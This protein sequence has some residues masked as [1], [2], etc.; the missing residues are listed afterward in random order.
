[1]KKKVLKEAY[2]WGVKKINNGGGLP[3]F[4]VYIDP[5]LSENSY[6]YKDQIKKYGAK[7]SGI[8]KYWYFEVSSDPQQRAQE[9]ETKVKP[10]V[11][12]LKSV[13][14]KP[15]N[16]NA[17]GQMDKIIS[18]IDELIGAART[19]GAEKVVD[20]V[21]TSFDPKELERRLEF[22]KEELIASFQNGTWKEKMAPIIKFRQAQGPS[23][24]FDNAILIQIQDPQSTMV[25][26]KSNW[27]AANK[28]VKAG[29][30]ALW[31]RVPLGKKNVTDKKQGTIDWL[32]KYGKTQQGNLTQEQIDQIVA[33]LTVGEKEKLKKYLNSVDAFGFKL[34]PGVYDVRFTEQ[35]EGKEDLIGSQEGIE[36]IAWYDGV[37]DETERSAHLYDAVVKAIEKS[38]VK[39][40]YTTDAE[41]DGARGVSVGG[42]IKVL[43]G[44]P[45][46]PGAVSTL[47]HEF[48]HELLHQNYLKR[49]DD[50]SK[51]FVGKQEGRA[52]VEQQAEISAWI[53]MRNFGYDMK[54]AVNYA[55]IWG[56]DDK[57]CVKVFNTVAAVAK[58][59]IQ[60]V[61]KEMSNVNESVLSEINLTGFDVARMLGSDALAAYKRGLQ[62]ME[63]YNNITETF[64]RV[65]KK[66]SR[67]FGY[68]EDEE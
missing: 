23:F 30:P 42:E 68:Y 3:M 8:G 28:N 1:M 40:S 50:L 22:F 14:K 58:Y 67:P 53:V 4:I 54:T 21:D 56:A 62:Q 55:G 7:W 20:E 15:N 46:S 48:S 49:N 44:I 63:E 31:I 66:I 38:T 57:S 60:N 61:D 26:S 41:L 59:I 5:K 6:E 47:V 45:K 33:S 18:M 2:E 16:L 52:I 29:A 64:N 12:F 13:E 43:Q 27:L 37:S 19:A 11:E 39:V 24:S 25:K 36:D 65:L 32:Q 34:I 35:I 9:I 17:Q 51:F 10:C